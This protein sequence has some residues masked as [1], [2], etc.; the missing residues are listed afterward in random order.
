M[1]FFTACSSH[2]LRTDS[3]KA[4]VATTVS[5]WDASAQP[6]EDAG[7]SDLASQAQDGIP[8][9]PDSVSPEVA[10]ADSDGPG[11]DTGTVVADAGDPTD[12]IIRACVLAVSCA[13]TNSPYTA[14]RCLREFA[15]TASRQDELRINHLL[16]CAHSWNC[17]D[18]KACW[19]GGLF[20]LDP[21]IAG[22]YCQG[23]ILT[24]GTGPQLDCRAF[25]GTCNSPPSQGPLA[26]CN[27]ISCGGSFRADCLGTTF[28]YCTNADVYISMDCAH[29]GR[30]CT[31]TSYGPICQGTGASCDASQKVTCSGSVATYCSHGALAQLDCASNG[32]ANQC[33]DG[34]DAAE[35]CTS[36]GSECDPTT[37]V[38][39]CDGDT[40]QVCAN[41]YI[42]PAKC[43]DLGMVVCTAPGSGYARCLEGE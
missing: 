40:L 20:T 17:A 33:A 16:D 9:V 15:K 7:P 39:R 31:I 26:S 6:W 22:G 29:S 3:G 27:P 8:F 32:L 30:S 37:F 1:A 38:D 24:L 11:Q 18:F 13:D 14:T 35:P 25:G 2:S 21:V 43:H 41:G 34:A 28:G 19:G 36:A 4:D 5:D 12:Q 23:T 10:Y 42:V